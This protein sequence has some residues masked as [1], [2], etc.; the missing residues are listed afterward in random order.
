MLHN[1]YEMWN[2]YEPWHIILKNW[3]E[4]LV[5]F[6]EHFLP[7]HKEEGDATKVKGERLRMA[8]YEQWDHPL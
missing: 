4:N 8:M 3:R 6:Y 1:F 2:Q 7:T 5:G